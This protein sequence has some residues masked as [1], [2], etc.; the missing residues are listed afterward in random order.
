MLRREPRLDDAGASWRSVLG[1][2]GEGESCDDAIVV[3]SMSARGPSLCSLSSLR[4]MNAPSAPAQSSARGTCGGACATVGGGALGSVEVTWRRPVHL[5][6][7]GGVPEPVD[8]L[9]PS[10]LAAREGWQRA[11]WRIGPFG[12]DRSGHADLTYRGMHVMKGQYLNSPTFKILGEEA[13]LRF[14]PNGFY[15]KTQIP[16]IFQD[17]QTNRGGDRKSCWCAVALIMPH[18]THLRLR[19]FVGDARS[20]TREVYWNGPAM[21]QQLWMVEDRRP[22]DLRDLVVG[23]DVFKNF[24]QLL[25]REAALRETQRRTLPAPPSESPL[26]A[27]VVAAMAGAATAPRG[28]PPKTAGGVAHGLLSLQE[29][30]YKFPSPRFGM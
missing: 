11:E 7:A 2:P 3:Q 20:D 27:A 30:G 4:S 19:F 23:V 21:Q 15:N 28:H 29:A 1:L 5:V 10:G 14:W 17:A 12:E 18:G 26:K 6:P 8:A 13:F 25:P 24:R 9:L 22:E 16:R